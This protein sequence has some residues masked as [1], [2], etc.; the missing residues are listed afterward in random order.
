[1]PHLFA[2][3]Y[4]KE[5][6]VDPLAAQVVRVEQE[7]LGIAQVVLRQAKYLDGHRGRE[8]GHDL[9]LGGLVQDVVYVVYEPHVEHRVGLVEHCVRY[10]VELD[11]AALQVVDEPARRGHYDLDALPERVKL[12]LHPLAAVDGGGPYASVPCKLAY[13]V[14]DLHGQLPSGR[15]DEAL[16]APARLYVLQHG[17]RVRGGLAR[18]RVR[19]PDHVP[20]GEQ[21]RYGRLLYGEGLVKAH[22]AYGVKQLLAYSQFLESCH[23]VLTRQ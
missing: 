11:R 4:D 18:A 22:V 20:A 19:L 13:L 1:M 9:V 12:H 3:L 8:Q 10:P 16:Y 5:R 15:H 23:P 17:D 21:D 2:I 7:L 14:R 6:L